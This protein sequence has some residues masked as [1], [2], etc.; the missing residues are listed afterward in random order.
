[1]FVGSLNDPVIRGSKIKYVKQ[2]TR[3]YRGREQQINNTTAFY[4]VL[5]TSF[6]AQAGRDLHKGL[7]ESYN[8]YKPNRKEERKKGLGDPLFLHAV[9]IF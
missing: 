4:T 8:T 6:V 5:F 1:M 9:S 3:D 7:S 2:Q